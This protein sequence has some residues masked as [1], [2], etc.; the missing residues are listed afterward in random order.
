MI[1]YLTPASLGCLFVLA[2]LSLLGGQ[3]LNLYFQ[4]GY[5]LGHRLPF[6]R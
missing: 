2:E 3:L 5:I 4:L 1:A 6:L